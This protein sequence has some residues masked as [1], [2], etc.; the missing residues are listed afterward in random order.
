MSMPEHNGPAPRAAM[1]I[2]TWFG[3]GNLPGA[4]GTWGSLAALPCAVVIVLVGGQWLLALAVLIAFV[5]GVWASARVAEWHRMRD[6]GFIV[7]DEV[8]GQWLAL[9]PVAFDWRFYP[10][11]FVLFRFA[12]ITKPWPANVLERAPGGVG[13]MADDIA[14]GVYAGILTWLIA[15]W[16][17]AQATLPTLF[18]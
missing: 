2:A 3:A 17:G 4:P 8:A 7:I 13:I 9:L 18:G 14:A 15:A 10:V 6:P 5:A 12:D 16:L 11:A 1:A